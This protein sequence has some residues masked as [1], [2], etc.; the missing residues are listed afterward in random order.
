[1][2]TTVLFVFLN[3]VA[4]AQVIIPVYLL[5]FFVTHRKEK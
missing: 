2:V 4:V 3:A 5:D 1:M